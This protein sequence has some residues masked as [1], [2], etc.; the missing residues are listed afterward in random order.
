M[1][2]LIFVSLCLSLLTS[3]VKYAEPT[4]LSLSGE[5]IVDRVTYSKV[6]NSSSPGDMDYQPG[7]I[8][9]NPNDIFPVDSIS[10][11]FTKWHLDYSVI[12]FNPISKTR[13]LSAAIARRRLML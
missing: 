8:Y 1:K 6:E 3:C 9:V 4:S 10:V 2:K 7:S 12:S 5:Y 13:P 11:G